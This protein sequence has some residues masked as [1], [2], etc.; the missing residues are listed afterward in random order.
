M[1]KEA[2]FKPRLPEG[3]VDAPGLGTVRVRGLSRAEV[4]ESRTGNTLTTERRMLAFGMLDPALTE[5][6]VKRWQEAALPAEIE[7]VSRRI[8][9]LSGLLEAS[10]RAAFRGTAPE[11]GA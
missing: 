9:E 8:A 5:D 7:S 3:E 2:L 11:Q 6:E 1:D 4:L 10:P